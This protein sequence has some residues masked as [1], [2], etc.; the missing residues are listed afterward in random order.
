MYHTK[1]EQNAST[2]CKR[3]TEKGT[4]TSVKF[5][6]KEKSSQVRRSLLLTKLSFWN[7]VHFSLFLYNFLAFIVFFCLTHSLSF[8]IKHRSI[9]LS[10][11]C[12]SNYPDWL[13]NWLTV[14]F[15]RACVRAYMCVCTCVCLCVC[16]RTY[17]RACVCECACVR[18]S[19]C[20]SVS[21]C[22][23]VCVCVWLCLEVT[24]CLST[25]LHA[26]P[27]QS[28]THQYQIH[29]FK[30]FQNPLAIHQHPHCNFKLKSQEINL[31]YLL[32]INVQR[33][34]LWRV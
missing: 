1:L 16:V 23:C 9:P 30:W 33:V 4:W 20:L 18:V 13:T 34:L 11:V 5:T 3:N 31:C 6:F 2:T 21:M 28:R 24:V 12:L 10:A 29:Q 27:Q 25:C 8:Y 15:V 32:S 17:V 22:V 14:V 26:L 19:V 7:S